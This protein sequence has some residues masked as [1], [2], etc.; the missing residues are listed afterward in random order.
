MLLFTASSGLGGLLTD[1]REFLAAVRLGR[2]AALWLLALLPLLALL[3]RYAARRRRAALAGVGRPAALTGQ[4]TH[5]RP[6]RR[7]AGLT[8]PLAWLLLVVG[9]AGPR[10]GE[11][12]EPGVAVGR[13][14]VIVID[15][16][17][18]MLAEDMADP[19]AKS[20]W[21]AARSGALDLLAAMERRGGHRVGV[22]LFAARPKLVCPLTTDYK[23]AR[24][25]LRAV[26]GR[27]PPPEC[28]PGPEA[29]ATSG[30]RFGAALVAAV[31]AHDPRFVGAQDIV[32]ISDGDDPEESD[33]EWVRGANAARTANVPVHTV[34]VGNPGQPT[35]PDLGPD[36]VEPFSTKLEEGEDKPLKLIAGETQ[37]E[38]VA[39]RTGPP[40]L[41]EFFL[42]CIEGHKLRTVVGDDQVPQPKERYPWL[43]APALALFFVGWLR[44]R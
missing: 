8:Y 5:P 13:D 32:L 38:Y 23:H 28:R 20:R 2:P 37:G 35:V 22:V 15:L 34:G 16:S 40:R 21:E 10:W 30:T 6:R 25:V 3:N 31:A 18:S 36:A 33:R 1:G 4:L 26:N 11:S 12:D 24:A 44:G 29:D 7:W 41:G 39:A 17:R 14:T 43:L 27:F 9:L 19:G 42:N